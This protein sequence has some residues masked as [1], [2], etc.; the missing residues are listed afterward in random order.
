MTRTA[1]A[2]VPR[3]LELLS[4]G[5][6]VAIARISFRR[7]LEERSVLIGRIAFYGVLLMV[8]SKI[9]QT[10]FAARG[11]AGSAEPAEAFGDYVGISWSPSG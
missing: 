11:D 7:R 9:W 5:K 1:S 3:T 8:F 10:V 2:S 6:Y 4:L